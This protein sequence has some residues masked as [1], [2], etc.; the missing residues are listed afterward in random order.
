MQRVA[1]GRILGSF[2]VLF[3]RIEKIPLSQPGL[4]DILAKQQFAPPPS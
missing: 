2:M 4:H 3:F 1:S